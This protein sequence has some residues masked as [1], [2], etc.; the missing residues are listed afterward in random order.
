MI[1]HLRQI[2]RRIRARLCAHTYRVVHRHSVG[3]VRSQ[4]INVE[5][6]LNNIYIYYTISII[7]YCNI[8]AHN[9]GSCSWSVSDA[10]PLTSTASCTIFS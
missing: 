9:G 4:R 2:L 3:R 10:M 5:T 8:I 6:M 1:D 7:L